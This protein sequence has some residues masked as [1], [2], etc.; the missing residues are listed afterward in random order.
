MNDDFG[1][2]YVSLSYVAKIS[3]QQYDMVN[4]DDQHSSRKWLSKKEL[5]E[6]ESV[7]HYTKEFL[8]NHISI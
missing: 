1:S 2:H 7:H 5:L 4:L 6:D 8:I 3:D